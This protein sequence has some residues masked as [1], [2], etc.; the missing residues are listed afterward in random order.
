MK[1]EE[2]QVLSAQCA[3]PGKGKDEGVRMKGERQG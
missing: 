1:D 2:R 3:V